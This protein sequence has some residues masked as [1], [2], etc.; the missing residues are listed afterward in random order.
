MLVLI[1]GGESEPRAQP[2]AYGVLGIHSRVS[3]CAL[4]ISHILKTVAASMDMR[5][6]LGRGFLIYLS[7]ST[8]AIV[9]VPR[10]F[11]QV[12]SS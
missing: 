10:R 3:C 4:A 6:R 8:P 2:G 12:S 7:A 5:S 1:G 11:G 9:F